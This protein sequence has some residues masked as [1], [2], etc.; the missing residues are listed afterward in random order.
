MDKKFNN[1]QYVVQVDVRK[2]NLYSNAINDGS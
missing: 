2:D 1:R